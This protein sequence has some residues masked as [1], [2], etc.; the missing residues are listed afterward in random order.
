MEQYRKGEY[1]HG[2]NVKP[3]PR[4]IEDFKQVIKDSFRQD[5]IFLNSLLI[6]RFYTDHSTVVHNLNLVESEG[7][8]SKSYE[9]RDTKHLVDVI[10]EKFGIPKEISGEAIS[11]LKELKD[12]WS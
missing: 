1:I 5:A 2:Y 6:T 10:E 3:E 11:E 7:T 12:P 4:K 8:N 9:L